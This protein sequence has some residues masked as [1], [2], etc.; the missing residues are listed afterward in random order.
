MQWIEVI[1]ELL[2]LGLVSREEL[3]S[4][5]DGTTEHSLYLLSVTSM[6]ERE[7][8]IYRCNQEGDVLDW[9]AISCTSYKEGDFDWFNH[10]KLV[11]EYDE[12]YDFHKTIVNTTTLIKHL[13]KLKH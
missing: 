10:K 6:A 11:V 12:R 7:T 9:D 1:K 8:C 3:A 5:V 13:Y 4:I 2:K